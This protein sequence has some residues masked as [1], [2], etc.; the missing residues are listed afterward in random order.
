MEKVVAL[1]QGAIRGNVPAPATEPARAHRFVHAD[2]T[3]N[4]ADRSTRTE[5]FDDGRITT[6]GGPLTLR[7][8]DGVMVTFTVTSKTVVREKET[9]VGLDDLDVGDGAMVFSVNGNLRL[10]RSLPRAGSR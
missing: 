5:D 6:T 7:R 4:R 9:R 1:A 3:S 10:V 2:L 8:P